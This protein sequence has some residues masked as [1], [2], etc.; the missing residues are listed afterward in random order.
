MRCS[1][2]ERRE[3]ALLGG[4]VGPCTA[5]VVDAPHSVSMLLCVSMLL[6][7]LMCKVHAEALRRRRI[8]AVGPSMWRA[9]RERASALIT[10]TAPLVAVL[11]AVSMLLSVS[12]LLPASMLL[13]VEPWRSC[14]WVRSG[15]HGCC[16]ARHSHGVRCC[17][18]RL[19]LHAVSMLLGVT[20]LLPEDLSSAYSAV[21]IGEIGGTRCP[22]GGGGGVTSVGG[23]GHWL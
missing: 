16:L 15:E 18:D 9:E 14:R 3:D 20:M 8:A 10:V 17:D 22:R 2:C 1:A 21:M 13:T 4:L 12:M 7:A 11:F 5:P 6:P 23:A 19:T